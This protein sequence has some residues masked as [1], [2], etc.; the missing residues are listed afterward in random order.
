MAISNVLQAV[1]HPVVFRTLDE[2]L[3]D[4]TGKVFAVRLWNGATWSRTVNPKFTVVLNSPA[5]LDRLFVHPS[6]L[7]IGEAYIAGDFDVEGDMEA[8]FEL[9][10]YLLRGTKSSRMSQLFLS[11]FDK[12][13]SH[14]EP[15]TGLQRRRFQSRSSVAGIRRTSVER[16]QSAN[17]REPHLFDRW[18]ASGDSVL[19][20]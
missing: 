19:P 3:A 16:S 2:A 15:T 6:E 9:G 8:A 10:D 14:E 1:W 7:G 17:G 18:V 4:Y 12:I 11:L 5:A 13:P 20:T